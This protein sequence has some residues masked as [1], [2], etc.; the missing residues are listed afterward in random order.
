[1]LESKLSAKKVEFK[2]PKCGSRKEMMIPTNLLEK[3]SI[4]LATVVVNGDCGH[5]Y[6]AYLDRQLKVRSYQYT[7]LFF[8]S[9]L[10][11]IDKELSEIYT[12]EV[13]DEVREKKVDSR[14]FE[15]IDRKKFLEKATEFYQVAQMYHKPFK[16]PIF[17]NKELI[18]ELK[19]AHL[20]LLSESEPFTTPTPESQTK[21]VEDGRCTEEKVKCE[22]MERLKKIEKYILDLEY[23]YVDGNLEAEVFLMKKTK[24]LQLEMKLENFYN[25]VVTNEINK[26]MK[27]LVEGYS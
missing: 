24:L 22:Y 26:D 21:V 8:M 5:N 14:I 4:N 16:E 10:E 19:S 27:R 17:L 23:E 7:D 13:S 6:I 12:G 2:C 25:H 11:K 9:E 15:E 1:M 20:E 3:H 18:E